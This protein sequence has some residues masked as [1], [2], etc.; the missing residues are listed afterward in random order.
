MSDIDIYPYEKLSEVN[1]IEIECLIPNN[2]NGD[3]AY[4]VDDISAFRH[5]LIDVFGSNPLIQVYGQFTESVQY[6]ITVAYDPKMSPADHAELVEQVFKSHLV[7][8]N[9]ER[10]G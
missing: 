9:N 5:D 7:E 10:N 2:R 6:A 8:V 3:D 4:K 1:N